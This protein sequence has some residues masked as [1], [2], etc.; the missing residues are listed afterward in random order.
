M[1]D[2]YGPTEI[3]LY[4]PTP[5]G[6]DRY[7]RGTTGQLDIATRQVLGEIIRL[8]NGGPVEW[9]ELKTF[10]TYDSPQVLLVALRR[11]VDL[12]YVVPV[13]GGSSENQ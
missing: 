7:A 13:T 6:A 12:G 11:L 5:L 1:S 4:Q 9:D 10:G 8:G 2:L 3:A